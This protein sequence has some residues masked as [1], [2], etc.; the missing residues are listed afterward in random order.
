MPRRHGQS[1]NVYLLAPTIN[2]KGRVVSQWGLGVRLMSIISSNWRMAVRTVKAI[3]RSCAGKSVIEPKVEIVMQTGAQN[4]AHV[5]IWQDGK[6]VV[7]F[8]DGDDSTER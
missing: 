7:D 6:S 1:S 2:A 8:V 3:Y 5:N 4:G